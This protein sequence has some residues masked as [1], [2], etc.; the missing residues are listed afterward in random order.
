MRIARTRESRVMT[1]Q[2]SSHR[3]IGIAALTVALTVGALSAPALAG[4]GSPVAITAGAQAML[5]RALGAQAEAAALGGGRAL[6]ASVLTSDSFRSGSA[7]PFDVHVL[8]GGGA[9]GRRDADKVRDAVLE[10]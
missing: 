1:S 10:T 6:F 2:P 7:G 5:K 8:A 9:S 3:A 4:P